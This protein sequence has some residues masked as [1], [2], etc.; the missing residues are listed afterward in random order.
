MDRPESFAEQLR[1]Y[2][3]ADGLSQEEL[4]ERAGLTVS[5]VGALE[6]GERRHPY[7][8]TIRVLAA[9]L[10]LSEAERAVLAQAASRRGA[11][12]PA[13]A[14]DRLPDLPVSPTRLVGRD[15]ETAAVGELLRRTEPR[16]VTLTGPGG[17]GKTRLA[18]QVAAEVADAYAD[19]VAFVPLA[20]ITDPA[21]VVP[22]IAGALGLR[23][24]AGHSL[25]D[26]LRAYLRAKRLLLVLDNFEHLLVAA[27]QVADMLA[28]C[29][30]PTV[31]V[32]SRAPLRL[33]GEQEYPVQPLALPD[34]SRVPAM[35]DAIASSAV[36]LFVERAR[37]A[38]PS[39]ALTEANAAAVSA[40][41]R[42]LDGLPLAL[43]LAAAW[44]K[45]LPPTALL[46]RLD[47]ALPLLG[48]GPRDLPE[49]QRTMRNAIAWS[50]DLLTPTEQV[51]FRRLAVFAGG[52]TLDAAEAVVAAAGDP[53]AAVLAGVL[54]L[55]DKSLVRRDDGTADEKSIAPRFGML[56][57]VREYAR[58]RLAASGE[59]EAIGRAHAAYFL[60]L[61]ERAEP[62]MTGSEEP[63]WLA[64]LDAEHDNLR[65]AFAWAME[66]SE[67]ET[68]LRLAG[69]LFWFWFT[70]QA[71]EGHDW[72]E[73]ALATHGDVAPAVRAK[74]ILV[75][76]ALAWWVE[77]DDRRAVSLTEESLAI[78]RCLGDQRGMAVAL[79]H[80]A[81]L[82]LWRGDLGRTEAL[83]E[84]GLALARAVGEPHTIANCLGSLAVVARQRGDLARSRELLG[85]ALALFRRAGHRWSIAAVIGA[86]AEVAR[87]RGAPAEAVA[88]YHERMLLYRDEGDAPPRL[89]RPGQWAVA[90]ALRGAAMIAAAEGR[91]EAAARLFGAAEA[92]HEAID[93]PVAPGSQD[94]HGR[95]VNAV[96]AELG[97]AAFGAAWSAGRALSID[98]V[99]DETASLAAALAAGTP[100]ATA[101]PNLPAGLS[102][103][104]VEVLR[105]VATGMTNAQVAER[106]YL[107]PRTVA[108][109]L[110][111]IYDKL[112]TSSRADAVRFTVE[113]GLT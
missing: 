48:G 46:A 81:H 86:L 87:D 65:A 10:G 54:A 41:C 108:A 33:R 70:R 111:R 55:V 19:G 23:E 15:R 28:A 85:E 58:E 50:H 98:R 88:L 27:P 1:R 4:A 34:L 68:G 47:R 66:R 30:G 109:H 95:A 43:E 83:A 64:R 94:A 110:R 113:H 105:L 57:T 75:A 80:L 67:V 25:R 3:A 59:A 69:A 18:L 77:K 6:R 14:E 53:D 31:L 93:I 60:D 104:E 8:H 36:Q 52:F 73:R 101:R 38:S 24:S 79:H 99:V 100:A 20:P 21:L 61:A 44:V 76:G 13:P 106:L 2:R 11:P 103:R 51:L 22:T 12:T 5:A 96:R 37:E 97:E 49:R 90:E 74:A 62:E 9:A 32:T 78:R 26:T 39:F 7:P 42:R 107:S 17:V 82:A 29:A 89:R 56:E 92:R 72:L 102:E 71:A 63:A 112:G 16:L 45:L 40:V 84:Q 35:G 91:W